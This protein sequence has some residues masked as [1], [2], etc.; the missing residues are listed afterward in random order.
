MAANHRLDGARSVLDARPRASHRRVAGRDRRVGRSRRRFAAAGRRW[1]HVAVS[2]AKRRERVAPFVAGR[3]RW[4]CR[5][6]NRDGAADVWR[7]PRIRCARTRVHWRS[8]AACTPAWSPRS[9]W[10]R[11]SAWVRRRR[12]RTPRRCAR[13][14][15]GWSIWRC[16]DQAEAAVA[17]VSSRSCRRPRRSERGTR[18]ID[19][20]LP[21]R[22]TPVDPGA[23]TDA[24]RSGA[25]KGRAG[26]AAAS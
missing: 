22:E 24:A 3:S 9:C 10:P 8:R 6:A 2:G 21:V 15:C 11:R 25:A 17:A 1:R 13:R 19:S 26:T 20:P 5:L 4:A 18:E 14:K 23:S 16:R 7:A 12:S